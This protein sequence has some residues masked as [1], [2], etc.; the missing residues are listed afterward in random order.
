MTPLKRMALAL[1]CVFLSVAILGVVS[2]VPMAIQSGPRDAL[3]TLEWWPVY[4]FCALPGWVIA[5]PFVLFF[6]HADGGRAWVMLAIGTAIGPCFLLSGTMLALHGQF[7][8]QRDGFGLVL[9]LVIGFLT[10]FLYVLTLRRTTGK[11]V[12]QQ[13]DSGNGIT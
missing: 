6:E 1:G 5:L 8:W 12:A 10:T 2:S 11:S 7:N 13:V 9:S 4:L 3:Q